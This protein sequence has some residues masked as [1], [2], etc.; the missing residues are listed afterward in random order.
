MENGKILEKV[1][2]KINKDLSLLD[3]NS[4]KSHEELLINDYIFSHDFAKAFW[5][6]SLIS[7]DER[8]NFTKFM[9]DAKKYMITWQYH[10]Q[11]MILEEEPLKYLEK[12]L[13]G[14]QIGK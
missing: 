4:E 5:G 2:K 8:G 10:L 1:F 7:L 12:F 6:E 9:V 3:F 11:Q 13:E 14:E